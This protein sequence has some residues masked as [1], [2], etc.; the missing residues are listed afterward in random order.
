MHYSQFFEQ[1]PKQEWE[2]AGKLAAF[3]QGHVVVTDLAKGSSPPVCHRVYVPRTH[4]VGQANV[5]NC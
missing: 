4:T 5:N 1:I 2:E 3:G